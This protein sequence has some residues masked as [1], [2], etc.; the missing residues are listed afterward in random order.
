M[1]EDTVHG[2]PGGRHTRTGV[3]RVDEDCRRGRL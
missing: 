3:R 1:R 2:P